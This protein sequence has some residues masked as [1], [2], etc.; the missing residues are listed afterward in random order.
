MV[1]MPNNPIDFISGI[2]CIL[3]LLLYIRILVKAIRN[4]YAPVKTVKAV[5][6]DKHKLESFSKYLGN[7]K[8]ERYVIVFLAECKKLSFYVSGFSYNGYK[9]KETGTLKYKGDKIIDFS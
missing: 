4:R 9:L 2:F 8:S 7:G 1:F 5:V 3:V 6:V